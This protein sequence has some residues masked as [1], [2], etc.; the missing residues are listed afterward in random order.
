M[1]KSLSADGY[2][3]VAWSFI[4]DDGSLRTLSFCLFPFM[5]VVPVAP[6]LGMIHGVCIRM[7]ETLGQHL[8]E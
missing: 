4:A 8:K 6:P 2:G 3:E 1:G 7:L 5:I